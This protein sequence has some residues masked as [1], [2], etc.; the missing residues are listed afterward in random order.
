MISDQMISRAPCGVGND[1]IYHN[2]RNYSHVYHNG[3]WFSTK[4][5]RNFW[6]ASIT[7]IEYQPL[8]RLL[9]PGS[10]PVMY[11]YCHCSFSISSILSQD[12]YMHS[13]NMR[14]SWEIQKQCIFTNRAS[15]VSGLLSYFNDNIRNSIS[16]RNTIQYISLN[17]IRTCF[18]FFLTSLLIMYFHI[19]FFFSFI[20][21]LSTRD[22][23]APSTSW[24]PIGRHNTIVSMPLNLGI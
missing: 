13:L 12:I 2:N 16:I 21:E 8:H 7:T 18:V 24:N 10:I 23:Y 11:L 5:N 17:K 19:W 20:Q 15:V 9:L 6:G 1:D 3:S 14:A 22:K 4:G